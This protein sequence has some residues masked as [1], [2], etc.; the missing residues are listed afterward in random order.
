MPFMKDY[1]VMSGEI[2]VFS[3]LDSLKD[4]NAGHNGVFIHAKK[5]LLFTS[6]GVLFK[7]HHKKTKQ[8]SGQVV[9]SQSHVHRI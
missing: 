4:Y 9:E 3:K 5:Y 8:N 1:P 7:S 2:R 6:K